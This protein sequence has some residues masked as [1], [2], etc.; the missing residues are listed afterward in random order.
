V[1]GIRLQRGAGSKLIRVDHAYEVHIRPAKAYRV[2]L[3]PVNWLWRDKEAARHIVPRLQIRRILQLIGVERFKLPFN[4]KHN[5]WRALPICLKPAW[6][7]IA[8][9]GAKVYGGYQDQSCQHGDQFS[10]HFLLSLGSSE[11][12]LG[13]ISALGCLITRTLRTLKT[14]F[15]AGLQ[16]PT[17]SLPALSVATWN[18]FLPA[19]IKHHFLGVFI[20]KDP[21]HYRQIVAVVLKCA[22]QFLQGRFRCH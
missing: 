3:R 1:R 10:F 20:T 13:T 18:V 9:A 4:S 7:N 19:R 17:T 21:F 14:F 11:E 12:I 5:K 15:G 2:E 6:D 16:V 8:S 22:L